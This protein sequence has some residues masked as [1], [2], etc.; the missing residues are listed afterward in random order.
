MASIW[1]SVFYPEIQ[2]MSNFT[3]EPI[4]STT[5]TTERKVIVNQYDYLE[6]PK[7]RTS[8]LA[9]TVKVLFQFI[10]GFRTSFCRSLRNGI[11]IGEI[12][13]GT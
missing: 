12:S 6:G 9:F 5:N 2:I 7:S 4:P 3:L 1:P 13:T 10:K 8:E 11:W